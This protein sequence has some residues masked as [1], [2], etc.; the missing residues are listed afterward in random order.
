LE[1]VAGCNYCSVNADPRLSVQR[2]KEQLLFVIIYVDDG[3]IIGTP[4]TI[5]EVMAA[6]EQSFKVKTMGEMEHFV[7]CLIS[8]IIDKDCVCIHQSK[9][10]N[11]LKEK[12]EV[13]KFVLTLFG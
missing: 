2:R 9:F 6:S 1:A 10:F 11:T 5:R 13:G 7:E 3:W 8:D 4:E 12:K